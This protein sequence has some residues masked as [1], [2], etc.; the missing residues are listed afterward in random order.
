MLI[1]TG[2]NIISRADDADYLIRKTEKMKKS[3]TPKEI[4]NL[5]DDQ[6]REAI[7]SLQ[8]VTWEDDDPLRLLS[9]EVYGPDSSVT[10]MLML[11]VPLAVELEERTN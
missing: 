1:F 10:T 4:K 11:A 9:C 6:L 2:I 7:R 3:R 8:N 5:N